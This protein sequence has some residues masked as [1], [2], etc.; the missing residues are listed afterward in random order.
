MTNSKR[1]RQAQF[2]K[3]I[4]T[5]ECGDCLKQTRETGDNES[6]VLLCRRCLTDAYQDNAHNDYGHDPKHVDCPA[7]GEA[8][9]PNCERMTTIGGRCH[10]PGQPD[11]IRPTGDGY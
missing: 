2:G 6:E 5:Y 9:C 11:P 1:T 8:E 3:R 10:C 4:P 7:C